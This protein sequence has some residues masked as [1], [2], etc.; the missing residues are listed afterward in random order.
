MTLDDLSDKEQELIDLNPDSDPMIKSQLINVYE[1]MMIL[2]RR[3]RETRTDSYAYIKRKV[4]THLVQYGAFLKSEDVKNLKEAE[5]NFK[6]ALK[7]EPNNPIAYYRLGFIKYR[8]EN[9]SE[10]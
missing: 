6:L 10:A 5:T 4:V 9:Y 7:H 1:H 2:M 8:N 3:K